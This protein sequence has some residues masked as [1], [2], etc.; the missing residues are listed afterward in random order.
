MR[1][2]LCTGL[3]TFVLAL[4]SCQSTDPESPG[5]TMLQPSVTG[6]VVGARITQLTE[7][8]RVLQL[9]DAEDRVVATY[10]PG[11]FNAT[12]VVPDVDTGEPSSRGVPGSWFHGVAFDAASG[13]VAVAIRGFV[14]A[15]TSFDLVYLIDTRAAG[16]S[17]DPYAGPAFTYLPFDGR[18]NDGV[19]PSPSVATRPWLD[20]VP[21]TV[22]FD[23]FGR[24]HLET[25]DASGSTSELIYAADL[26]IDTCAWHFAGSSARCPDPTRN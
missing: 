1:S 9:V 7:A 21:E 17:A 18:R 5:H 13:R 8:A 12:V 23:A 14:Y 25:A 24:L 20:L 11:F 16:F 10:Y 4:A 19:L 15:E 26:T 3:C 2:R 6:G 22:S